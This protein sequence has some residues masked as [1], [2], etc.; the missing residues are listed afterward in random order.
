MESRDRLSCEEWTERDQVR[1]KT[2]GG[3]RASTA[4]SATGHNFRAQQQKLQ[5]HP[6]AA[7]VA[8]ETFISGPSMRLVPVARSSPSGICDEYAEAERLARRFFTPVSQLLVALNC[9]GGAGGAGGCAT[10]IVSVDRLVPAEPTLGGSICPVRSSDDIVVKKFT[11]SFDLSDLLRTGCP[12][13]TVGPAGLGYYFP[14]TFDAAE[15]TSAGE[16]SSRA[17]A[18]DETSKLLLLCDVSCGKMS[19]GKG[20]V[21]AE[22]LL[23]VYRDC[24]GQRDDAQAMKHAALTLLAKG[25]YHSMSVAVD[26]TPHIVSF[27]HNRIRPLYIVRYRTSTSAAAARASRPPLHQ[28]GADSNSTTTPSAANENSVAPKPAVSASKCTLPLAQSSRPHQVKVDSS[29]RSASDVAS[30]IRLSCKDLIEAV[31]VKREEL[32]SSLASRQRDKGDDRSGDENDEAL[33]AAADAALRS[34][35]DLQTRVSAVKL[36]SLSARPRSG[37][38]TASTDSKPQ[39]QGSIVRPSTSPGVQHYH[40]AG[41]Q[42]LK[43]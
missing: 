33:F 26:G 3:T 34:L 9:Q 37:L 11:S 16:R 27:D 13:P 29:V 36:L 18:E 1:R 28:G 22:D 41:Q 35:A 5:I 8:P 12:S 42:R 21:C 25:G 2:R 10:E 40:V 31:C 6:S 39:Q 19:M 38:A 4:V 43:D 17:V 14:N 20:S 30:K 32:L 7:G 15:S 24:A 23:R